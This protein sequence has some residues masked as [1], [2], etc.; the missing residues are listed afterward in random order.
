MPKQG[1]RDYLKNISPAAVRDAVARPFSD[2]ECGRLLVELGTIMALLPR[3]PARLLDLGCGTGWTSDFFAR[4]GYQVLGI[5]ISPD[6]IAHASRRHL[7]DLRF[8]VGDYEEMAFDDEFDAAVFCASLHHAVDEELALRRVLAALRPGGVCVACE[9]GAGHQASPAAK[10]A[11][12]RC[13]VTEKDMPPARIIALG[14]KVGFVRCRIVP[15][16]LD[17][18]LTTSPPV[19]PRQSFRSVIGSLPF[20]RPVLLLRRLLHFVRALPHRGGVVVLEK[21]RPAA[22][23]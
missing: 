22:P 19:R 10:E 18:A 15:H 7:P 5:D 16:P 6:M 2:P 23:A 14:T 9:P 8:Q 11:V 20:A 12:R 13:R 3:P 1:E 17:L 21:D 4:Q